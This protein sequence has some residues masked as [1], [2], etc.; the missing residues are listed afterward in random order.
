MTFIGNAAVDAGGALYAID[1]DLLQVCNA[2]FG[3]NNAELGGAVVVVVS[4][5]ETSEFSNC[6]F[7]GN[8]AVDGGAVYLY[9]STGV[10]TFTSSVFRYNLAGEGFNIAEAIG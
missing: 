5:D 8:T 6:M 10:D 7:D 2:T 9:T 4:A 1:C 3:W